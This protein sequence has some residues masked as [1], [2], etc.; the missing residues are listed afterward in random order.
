MSLYINIDTMEY[1]RY[2]GDIELN[3]NANWV[4][5]Q[6]VPMPEPKEG[7]AHVEDTPICI[8]GVWYQKWKEVEVEKS[9]Y[10]NPYKWSG[11]FTNEEIAAGAL[12]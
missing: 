7:I 5:V 9:T 1:P 10:I 4:E 8:D 12:L 6:V 11:D 2:A 3:P